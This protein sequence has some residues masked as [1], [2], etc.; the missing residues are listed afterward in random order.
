M[1]KTISLRNFDFFNLSDKGLEREKNE[2]Y[3]AYFDTFNG[4]IFVVCDGMGGHKGGEV[5]SKIAVEAIGVY[6]NTQYYKNPFEAVE[7]AISIANKKVFI[8]AKHNDELFGMGTTM[9]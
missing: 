2:D 5:A 8:H 4:H 1:T 7:N 9:V 3:L 6:F